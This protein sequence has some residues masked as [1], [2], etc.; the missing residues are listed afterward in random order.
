MTGIK[1]KY[2]AARLIVIIISSHHNQLISVLC[3]H[4][5]IYPCVCASK[6]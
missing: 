1:K 2:S 3:V 5:W 4:G 6:D